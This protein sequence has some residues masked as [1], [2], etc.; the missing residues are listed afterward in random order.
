[1]KKKKIDKKL[2]IN[3]ETITNLQNNLINNL[4]DI[5]GGGSLADLLSEMLVSCMCGGGGG[6]NPSMSECCPDTA[7]RM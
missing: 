7:E 4:V 3:K 6:D 2:S 5:K 1:M